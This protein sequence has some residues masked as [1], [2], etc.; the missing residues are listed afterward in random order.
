MRRKFVTHR[1]NRQLHQLKF[2][3][4]MM[5][6]I[7]NI[8]PL[9]MNVLTLCIEK[10]KLW[11]IWIESISLC[12]HL[13]LWCWLFIFCC[14]AFLWTTYSSE[15]YKNLDVLFRI[16]CLMCIKINYPNNSLEIFYSQVMNLKWK[17]FL[18]TH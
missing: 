16:K 13:S 12:L 6:L 3:W 8:I 1:V 15:K 10:I 14:I 18:Q 4:F 11:L 2:I 17:I 7:N 9:C 5:T